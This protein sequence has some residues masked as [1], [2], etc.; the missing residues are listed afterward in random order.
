MTHK[1]KAIVFKSAHTLAIM[2]GQHI[3]EQVNVMRA[4]DH[5]FHDIQVGLMSCQLFGLSV[6]MAVASYYPRCL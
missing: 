4:K 6:E 2:L 3:V 5:S 1:L